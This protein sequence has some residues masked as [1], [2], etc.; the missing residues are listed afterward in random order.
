M[1]NPSYNPEFWAVTPELHRDRIMPAAGILFATGYREFL[2]ETLAGFSEADVTA[3]AHGVTERFSSNE[4]YGLLRRHNTPEEKVVLHGAWLDA[5]L[6]LELVA[7]RIGNKSLLHARMKP[8]KYT[9]EQ[10]RWLSKNTYYG[11]ETIR[12]QA[13]MNASG[14]NAIRYFGLSELI[15]SRRLI[16]ESDGLT[17][18]ELLARIDEP[19]FLS[20]MRE[21]GKA[22]MSFWAIPDIG[23]LTNHVISSID[24]VTGPTTSSMKILDGLGGIEPSIAARMKRQKQLYHA[25]MSAR[26]SGCPVRH[27]KLSSTVAQGLTEEQRKRAEQVGTFDSDTGVFTYHW[28]PFEETIAGISPLLQRVAKGVGRGV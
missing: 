19:D 25:D 23:V 14:A 22:A 15:E 9:P 8:F 12:F 1:D 4:Q 17:A 18:T 16:G 11:N 26:S 6:V 20:S 7:E 10:T 5:A 28:H 21:A 3:M 24:H 13:E 27:R 2:D